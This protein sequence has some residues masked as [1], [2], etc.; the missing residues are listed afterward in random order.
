MENIS[1]NLHNLSVGHQ[2][3]VS[4]QKKFNFYI[5]FF[6]HSWRD[7]K[8]TLQNEHRPETTIEFVVQ[9]VFFGLSFLGPTKFV[10]T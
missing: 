3:G 1:P 5:S 7:E 2:T 10:T 6:F 9:G 4:K 8:K